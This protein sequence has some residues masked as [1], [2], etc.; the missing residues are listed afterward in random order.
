MTTQRPFIKRPQKDQQPAAGK[1]YPLDMSI[2][3]AKT[4]PQ[5]DLSDMFEYFCTRNQQMQNL[6]GQNACMELQKKIFGP[7]LAAKADKEDLPLLSLAKTAGRDWVPD[8]VT[9]SW[10]GYS[11]KIYDL[12]NAIAFIL[13]MG[14]HLH[15]KDS[16]TPQPQPIAFTK[17]AINISI[18]LYRVASYGKLNPPP[19]MNTVWIDSNRVI[20]TIPDTP[21]AS[22]SPTPT[23]DNE[24]VA[25]A[26]STTTVQDDTRY[27]AIR[28]AKREE[29]SAALARWGVLNAVQVVQERL[30][31]GHRS[32]AFGRCAETLPYLCLVLAADLPAN[33]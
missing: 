1:S 18:M 4:F 16:D 2:Y 25:A 12:W 5:S 8:P 29:I 20:L 23:T 22:T 7:Y 15:A 32:D 10:H 21:A 6:I 26:G 30:G 28:T 33:N 11:V 14:N 9:V 24:A 27:L 17:L 31:D 19:V 13:C 3:A